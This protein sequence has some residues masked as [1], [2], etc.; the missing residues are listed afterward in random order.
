[1]SQRLKVTGINKCIYK[2]T[3]NLRLE[4]G[5]SKFAYHRVLMNIRDT[6]PIISHLVW[7]IRTVYLL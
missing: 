6:Y 3:Y 1:M 4:M 5:F 2:E 7:I